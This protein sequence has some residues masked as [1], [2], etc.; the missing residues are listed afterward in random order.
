MAISIPV[1]QIRLNANSNM[2]EVW[3]GK[4]WL[5][6]GGPNVFTPMPIHN[7]S[8]SITTSISNTSTITTNGMGSM[9]KL[10]ENAKED[11]Y[12]FLR[13]NLRVAEYLNENGKVDYVQLEIREGDGYDWENIQRVRIKQ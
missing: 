13:G 11:L 4:D 2:Q 1:G 9:G 10:T 12:L 6:L 3:D 5:E 8:G 7:S